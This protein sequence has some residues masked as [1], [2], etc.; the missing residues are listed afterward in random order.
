MSGAEIVY[1]TV[2]RSHYC[3]ELRENHLGEQVRLA[4]WVH[5]W[6]DLGNLVF[7]DLR[8]IRGLCQIVFSA[9]I[10]ANLHAAASRLRNEYVIAV[11]GQVRSRPEGMINPDLPSGGIEV[12]AHSLT[13]LNT[14]ATPPFPIG[15]A[16]A[17][18]EETRL[19]YRYLDLRSERMKKNVIFRHRV[20]QAIRQYLDS[21][22]FL[23]IE[24][25]VLM[26][27]TP[28]GARD[29]IVPSRVHP[30]KFYALPQSPQLY[31]QMLMIGGL[32]RYYQ[33]ARCFRDED[34]RGDKQPEHT[35]IDIE[36]SMSSQE[37]IFSL[38]ENMFSHIFR[39]VLNAELGTPF[40]RI[41]YQ[42]AMDRF[43]TD[44]PDL[45]FGLELTDLTEL[46]RAMS[47]SVFH[48]VLD[49]G[50]R[51]KGLR[52]P[53]GSS[54]SRKDIQ[55]WE[56][57]IKTYFGAAGLSW[58]KVG[59]DAFQGSVAKFCNEHRQLVLETFKAVEGDLLLMVAGKPKVVYQSLAD[60]RLKAGQ[61]LKLVPT[62]VYNF[63][64]VTDFPLFEWDDET[65]KWEA[66]HHLFTMP[67]YE[68]IDLLETE[69]G[70]IHGQL[71]D[72]VLNGVELASGSIRIHNR[73]LQER[74]FRV[75]G[76][77]EQEAERRFGFFLRSLEYGAPPHGG[78]AP[79]LDRI[80]MLLL[81][82]NT[83]RDV[84]PF[85]KTLTAYSPLDG[86]PSSVDEVQLRETHI[87]LDLES[88]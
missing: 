38:V 9:D 49:Q 69:P 66:V 19:E 75:V 43:G 88:Q 48:Q 54:L 73:Q 44:K 5:K 36:M 60:L 61:Y 85:P 2:Q 37:Q 42:Q 13:V 34:L 65:G 68:D 72:L 29:Y 14:S 10:D 1:E 79:G 40:E 25:P 78:I 31:K 6:R 27:S 8:D 7:I 82:E 3:G 70:N 67:R 47:F 22:H 23:E 26:K 55:E 50:G 84:I 57:N 58:I 83:I 16:E 46:A 4:G 24:T 12:L 53:G 17:V 41:T 51:V 30:G 87:R 64:W 81:K 76:I 80:L 35:Q 86:C 39:V 33:I 32:D 11:S 63:V 21:Q 71:Y 15:Q 28:E 52:I 45:C 74:I 20:T 56:A 62:D 77:T 59:P 18:N